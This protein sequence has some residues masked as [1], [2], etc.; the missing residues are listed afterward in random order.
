MYNKWDHS[1]IIIDGDE[2][3][4]FIMGYERTAEGNDQYPANTL[5]ISELA[6]AAD[7]QQQGIGSSL[8]RAFFEHNNQVGFRTLAGELNYSIQTNSADWNEH[9]IAL[10]KSFGF[11]QRSTKPYP[12]RTDVVLGVNATGLKLQ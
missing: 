9:V 4:A 11:T 2:P 5:Y 1:L 6:V 12:N 8:L 3:V 7:K 10:Y